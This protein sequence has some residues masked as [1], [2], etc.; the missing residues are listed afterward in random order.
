MIILTC[1]I[2]S[3]HNYSAL[4]YHI[5]YRP[6][7]PP[8]GLAAPG[9]NSALGKSGQICRDR[10][11]DRIKKERLSG[12]IRGFTGRKAFLDLSLGE[13]LRISK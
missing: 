4:G 10:R 8:P 1:F 12:K 5:V 7:D 11:G 13:K 3:C 2:V 9:V 6:T